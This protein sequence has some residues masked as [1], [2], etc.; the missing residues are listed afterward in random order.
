MQKRARWSLGWVC[1]LAL[2]L[3]GPQASAKAAKVQIKPAKTFKKLPKWVRTKLTKGE[4]PVKVNNPKNSKLRG[5][6][7]TAWIIVNASPTKVYA[8]MIKF[9]KRYEYMPRLIKSTITKRLTPTTLKVNQVMKVMW[10]KIAVNLNISLTPK[11]KI[12]WVLD[13]KKKN[14]VKE[15]IGSWEFEGIDNN[16]KTMITYQLYT[17]T[18]RA[19][20]GFIRN[21]LIK[22]DLPNVL[23]HVR[24]RVMS[25]G[26]WKK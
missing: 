20:P 17:E 16:K 13:K 11:K 23:R 12:A 18:G 24:K 3:G 26:K 10:V 9:D 22:S 19:V 5:A 8:E 4:V 21:I 1:L 25:N 2:C 7:A 15:N 6:L 14:G